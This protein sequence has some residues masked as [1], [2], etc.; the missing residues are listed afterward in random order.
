MWPPSWL[1]RVFKANRLLVTGRVC[2]ALKSTQS[3]PQITVHLPRSLPFSLSLSAVICTQLTC[4]ITQ[5]TPGHRAGVAVTHGWLQLQGNTVAAVTT[6]TGAAPPAG[7]WSDVENKGRPAAHAQTNMTDLPTKHNAV[8][9]LLLFG[10]FAKRKNNLVIGKFRFSNSNI[11][12]TSNMGV[13]E[14]DHG[15]LTV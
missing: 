12:N 8:L 10:E 13:A 1:V 5:S 7:S 9:V 6:A 4:D 15:P 3:P 14:S 2:H 11:Y